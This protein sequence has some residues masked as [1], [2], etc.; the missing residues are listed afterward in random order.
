MQH[1]SFHRGTQSLRLDD[2]G[3]VLAD[4]LN[5][6]LFPFLEASNTGGNVM[7]SFASASYWDMTLNF[8]KSVQQAGI[9][10]L[11]IVTM[12]NASSLFAS[13]VGIPFFPYHA[14]LNS[15]D[16]GTDEFGTDI[17]RDM[18]NRRCSLIAVALRAGFNILLSDVDVVW[19]RNPFPFFSQGDYDLEIQ[20]DSRR[21]FTERMPQTPFSDFVNAGLFY[22]RG[23][24]KVT[25]LFQTLADRLREDPTRDDQTELNRLLN[26]N[27][28]NIRYRV[29]DPVLFPNGFQHFSRSISARA[30]VDPFCIHNNWV[31]GQ[32]TK[33][34]RFRE[35]GVWLQDP[36]ERLDG[37][38]RYLAIYE[39]SIGNNGWNNV[40]N[41]LRAGLAIAQVLNRTLILPKT[42]SHHMHP[43]TV[44]LDYYL[45]Y[46]DFV[47]QFP[48]IREAAFVERVFSEK[49]D[50]IFHIDIGPSSHGNL[51][52]GVPLVNVTAAGRFRGAS[53]DELSTW[54]A[55]YAHQRVLHLTSSFRRFHKFLN[56]SRNS[57]FDDKLA[58]ALKPSSDVRYAA[59]LVYNLLKER[60]NASTGNGIFNCVHI[61]RGDFLKVHEAERPLEEIASLLASMLDPTTALYVASD[62][63][64]DPDFQ[65][66]LLRRFPHAFFW[67]N[68][69]QPAFQHLYDAELGPSMLIGAIEQRLCS[70]GAKFVGNIYSTFTTHVCFLRGRMGKSECPDIYGREQPSD[71]PF[72]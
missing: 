51:P 56:R 18:V 21:A 42:Y 24:P 8:V 34:Y 17:F 54:F 2:E 43:T 10:N 67:G 59:G 53:D 49:P 50:Q 7:V 27:A 16:G 5:A 31:I 15:S 35:A 6:S 72:F 55:P 22:A 41:S 20:S 47:S 32:T 3:P 25:D 36:P 46:Q 38:G 45:S 61:R 9:P 37:T 57:E 28:F 48:N 14:H 64:P 70:W 66:T 40:R 60:A 11:L 19:K 65:K 69:M 33:I 58:K 26:D 23:I 68:F 71:W 30:G 62:A 13:E 44:T 52:T 63:S 39:P 12:D 4:Q 29:L 1:T